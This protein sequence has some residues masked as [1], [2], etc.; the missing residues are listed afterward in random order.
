MLGILSGLVD[1][2]REAGIPVSTT[3][4]IDAARALE[5]IDVFD[6]DHVRGALAATLV[7]K[8]DHQRTF[9]VLFD[10]YFAFAPAEPEPGG[11]AAGDELGAVSGG[12][13]LASWLDALTDEELR[14]R[15][16]ESLLGDDNLTL[17]LMV[18]QLV[19]R[20]AR[21]QPGQPVTGTF[22]VFRTLR[23]VDTEQLRHDL[24]DRT[25]PS[26]STTDGV[27]GVSP[28]ARRLQANE[29]EEM[30]QHLQ[31]EIE[32]EVRRR[33][34]ADR[35]AEA[36]ARSLRSTLPEDV[37][38]LTAS[39][40][41]LAELE[42]VLAPLPVQMA[43][44]L[45][46]KRRRKH[47]SALDFRRTMRASMA[48]GGVPLTLYRKRPRPP[49]PELFI[50]ADISGSVATFARFTLQLAYAMRSQ[51]RSVRSFAFIDGV[52]EIT[53]IVRSSHNIM[54]IAERV[55]EEKAGLR[56]DGRSDYG[57]ALK[58]F[59]DRFGP[60]VGSRTTILILG[61]GRSNYRRNEIKSMEAIHTR[62][63]HVYWLN[64]ERKVSWDSGDSIVGRYAPHCDGVFEC[65]N[66][67]QLKEFIDVLD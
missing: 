17:R 42:A 27:D 30:I 21:I 50:L 61:D 38:F 9:Y 51:F 3:E 62:A 32:A 53:E 22:Y 59:A 7:K 35:G 6:R 2:L 65:R 60:Q 44:R 46:E 43:R 57:Q 54:E 37:D 31:Q 28:L 18:G 66:L 11:G 12:T 10:L 56:L 26:S 20:H 63:A 13:G 34:V 23:A 40:S 49:R 19:T 41:E 33:V 25:Q 45:A 29:V 64:P 1:S 5:M 48:S 58:E 36:V 8:A 55:D 24:T 67:R 16:I 15:L 4:C 14:E 47:R 39:M 52:D